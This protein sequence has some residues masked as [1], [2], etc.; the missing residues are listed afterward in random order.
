[1]SLGS[2]FQTLCGALFEDSMTL[3]C[4]AVVPES[5][6]KKYRNRMISPRDP[7]SI[8]QL[9][10]INS[11]Y[12]LVFHFEDMPDCRTIQ[13]TDMHNLN[14]TSHTGEEKNLYFGYS[15]RMCYNYTLDL[16]TELKHHCGARGYEENMQSGYYYTNHDPNPDIRSDVSGGSLLGSPTLVICLIVSLLLIA[17]LHWKTSRL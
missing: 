4:S 10:S 5:L 16:T 9:D 8:Y 14:C 17:L 13:L 1:M 3:V 11:S 2:A 15:H 7:Y 12:L 6:T